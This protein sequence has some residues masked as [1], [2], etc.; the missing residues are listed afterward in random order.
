MGSATQYKDFSDLYTGLLNATREQTTSGSA[1]VT[2]AQR[3]INV[4]LQDMHI[5]FEERFPWSE[6]NTSLITHPKYTTGTVS[7]S[8]GSTTLTGSGTAF[9]TDNAWGDDNA[10]TTGKLIISGTAP[11][12]TIASVDSATQITLNEKYV[13]ATVSGGTYLYYEDEYDLHADFLRPIDIHSFDDD[14]SIRLLDR[15]RFRREYVR[16]NTTGKPSVA[17]I[18]DRAFVSSTSPVRRVQFY[19]P[20][21]DAYDIPYS[22]VTNKLAVNASGTASQSLVNDTDEPIVPFSYRHAIVFHALYHWYRDKKD[23][24]RTRE[25]KAEYEQIMARIASSTEIGERRPRIEPRMTPYRRMARSPYRSGRR[26]RYTAGDAF[27]ELR[28]R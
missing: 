11:V 21:D 7:I 24:D 3:Y 26:G 12:Y 23:D 1:T 13:G 25:A 5:G 9:T 2:Q 17:T 15:T 27:D 6:R 22:F 20:P 14:R 8:Q 18:V 28:D 19:K 16:V 4:A 10:R